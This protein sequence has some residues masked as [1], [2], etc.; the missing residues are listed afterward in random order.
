M[1]L[2]ILNMYKWSSSSLLFQNLGSNT[3]LLMQW[4][5]EPIFER[6]R[7]NACRQDEIRMKAANSRWC[8][9]FYIKWTQGKILWVYRR[10]IVYKLHFC[11]LVSNYR[12]KDTFFRNFENVL[13]VS[14]CFLCSL[15]LEHKLR[16]CSKFRYYYS[17]HSSEKKV[18]LRKIRV[19][20]DISN[21]IMW[22]KSLFF[23]YFPFS[24]CILGKN[25]FILERWS[26]FA[27]GDSPFHEK[28]VFSKS[29]KSSIIFFE[30]LCLP[31]IPV[32]IPIVT[33]LLKVSRISSEIQPNIK[34]TLRS[35]LSLPTTAALCEN[36]TI[37]SWKIYSAYTTMQKLD[38]LR[39][40]INYIDTQILKLLNTRYV[41][42]QK[43]R[44][45]S[46]V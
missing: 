45:Y 30:N 12:V 17:S 5:Y 40:C 7:W 13:V 11:H 6:Q 24:T 38:E 41:R 10:E 42:I 8:G 32:F 19:F 34:Y 35:L 28:K 25:K 14:F 31:I 3:F 22:K 33:V 15:W 29:S 44:E 16:D 4:E 18:L 39:E 21:L 20:E 26:F 27:H 36:F 2:D 23:A 1:I 46:S 43:K 9:L 37:L